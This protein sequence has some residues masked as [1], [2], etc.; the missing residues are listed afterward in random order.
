VFNAKELDEENGMYY[1]SARHYN[2]PTFISR[3]PLFEVRPWMSGYAY[4]S[5]NPVN[6]FDPTGLFDTKAE[7]KAY[8]KENHIKGKVK[9]DGASWTIQDRKNKVSIYRDNSNTPMAGK[10]ENGIVRSVLVSPKES[11]F[12]NLVKSIGDFFSNIN[13][14]FE[15][16]KRPATRWGGITLT[17][18]RPH[19]G[20]QGPAIKTVSKDFGINGYIYINMDN[21]PG[22]IPGTRPNPFTPFLTSYQLTEEIMKTFERENTRFIHYSEEDV[23]GDVSGGVISYK[24][25]EDSIKKA[26]Y[27]KKSR[28]KVIIK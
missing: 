12:S 28:N 27:L 5:N 16:D 24:D 3:D 18:N 9:H 20:T 8:K 26:E 13:E 19:Q 10:D 1:Y 2:P 14:W 21:F 23:N 6:R 25:T 17:T 11:R 22:S 15:K 4:C 7:A